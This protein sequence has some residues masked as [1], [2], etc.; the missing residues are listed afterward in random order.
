MSLY[1]IGESLWQNWDGEGYELADPD[2]VV[3]Y[4]HEHVDTANPYVQQ[5]LARHIHRDGVADSLGDAF[6]LLETSSAQQGYAGGLEGERHLNVCE[7][8]GTTA[9][10]ETVEAILPVTWVEVYPDEL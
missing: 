8:T 9:L 3:Y 2:G 1:E 5:A 6:R 10:G 4:V 7:H